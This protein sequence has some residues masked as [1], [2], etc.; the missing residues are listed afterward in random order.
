VKQHQIVAV[1]PSK[2]TP[3]ERLDDNTRERIVRQ[4]LASVY[5]LAEQRG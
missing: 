1:L 4:F 3:P 5:S 2:R